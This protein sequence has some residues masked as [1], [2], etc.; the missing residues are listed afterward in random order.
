M[1][2]SDDLLLRPLRAVSSAAA[3][4]GTLTIEVI[5]PPYP[6]AGVGMLRVVRVVEAEGG[7]ALAAAYEGYERL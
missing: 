7:V 4:G 3:F 6:C 1:L 5:A 2:T